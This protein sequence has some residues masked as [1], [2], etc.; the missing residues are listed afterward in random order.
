MTERIGKSERLWATTLFGREETPT[1]LVRKI[2]ATIYHSVVLHNPPNS[3]I[4]QGIRANLL[5][6]VSEEDLRYIE[7]EH[8]KLREHTI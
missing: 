2:A 1:N 5:K 4:A 6:L 7:E 8:E 3:A